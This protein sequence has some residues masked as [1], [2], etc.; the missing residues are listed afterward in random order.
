MCFCLNRNARC[1]QESPSRP[2]P[3]MLRSVAPGTAAVQNPPPKTNAK[4]RRRSRRA[5]RDLVFGRVY[6]SGIGTTAS[7]GRAFPCADL[8]TAARIH[9][10]SASQVHGR[11]TTREATPSASSGGSQPGS[12]LTAFSLQRLCGCMRTSSGIHREKANQDN[13]VVRLCCRHGRRN[14]PAR[15][16]LWWPRRGR[17]IE[18]VCR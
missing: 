8:W 2:P 13:S 10:Y 18:Y 1:Q 15:R 3:K 6:S 4:I 14:V 7:A 16:R 17:H 9:G 5:R 12:S 11:R